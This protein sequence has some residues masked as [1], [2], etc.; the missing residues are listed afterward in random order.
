MNRPHDTNIAHRVSDEVVV[1][2]PPVLRPFIMIIRV[3]TPIVVLVIGGW[4]AAYMLRT[5]PKAERKVSEPRATAVSVM[6]ATQRDTPVMVNAM[7]TVMPAREVT[8]QPRVDGQVVSVS[9][10]FQP[11]GLIAKGGPLLQIDRSD[12]ELTIA[13]LTSALKQ[14]ESELQLEK[15]RQSVAR[16]EFELIG[17]PS[18]TQDQGLMLR[19]PQLAIAEAKVDAAQAALDDA[20]LDLDRTEVI[21]PFNAQILDRLVE[22]GTHVSP[23]TKLVTLHGTDEYWVQVSVP[24]GEL[25]WIALDGTA[26]ATISDTAAWSAGVSR[27]GRVIRLLGDLEREGRMAKLLVVVQDPLGLSTNT[28]AKLLIGS[29]VRVDI[30]GTILKGTMVLDRSSIRPGNTVWVADENDQLVIKAVKIVY[31]DRSNVYVTEGLSP[32]DRIITN[33][34]STPVVGM[35]LRVLGADR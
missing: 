5:G 1:S 21:A 3:M 11:G 26:T 12:Y 16:R 31:R 27:E 35:S 29:F 4:G 9:E 19:K 7:G 32:E 18:A 25:K 33:D 10:Q 6:H 28:S 24:V 15:G 23:S 13:R 2:V 14:A 8:L 34:L 22:V 17:G 30:S 20:K